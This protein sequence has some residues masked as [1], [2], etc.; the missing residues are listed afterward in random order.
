MAWSCADV[1]VCPSRDLWIC[2]RIFINFNINIMPLEVTPPLLLQIMSAVV[3][4][5]TSGVV[6]TLNVQ[7]ETSVALERCDFFS[8][9]SFVII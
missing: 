9:D 8:Q 1:S 2:W 5:H 6:A 4:L 7:S 3:A